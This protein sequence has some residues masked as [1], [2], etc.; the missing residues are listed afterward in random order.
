MTERN[1]LL[2]QVAKRA[3]RAQLLVVNYTKG[4]CV[5][6]SHGQLSSISYTCLLHDLFLHSVIIS[7]VMKLCQP[8]EYLKYFHF[9]Q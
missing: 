4:L 9:L 1:E 8:T 2:A 7:T 5:T 3:E 6:I